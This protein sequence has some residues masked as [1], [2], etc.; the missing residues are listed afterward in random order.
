MSGCAGSQTKKAQRRWLETVT[1]RT[2]EQRGGA[3]GKVDESVRRK[4]TKCDASRE[5]PTPDALGTL[6]LPSTLFD[7]RCTLQPREKKGGSVVGTV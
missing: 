4:K 6:S 5:D 3:C 2:L 1:T 7:L